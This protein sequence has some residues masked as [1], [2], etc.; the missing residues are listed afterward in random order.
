MK[1]LSEIEVAKERNAVNSSRL[2]S[3]TGQAVFMSWEISLDVHG[4][5]NQFTTLQIEHGKKPWLSFDFQCK[6]RSFMGHLQFW[7]LLL[8][9][10]SRESFQGDVCRSLGPTKVAEKGTFT[11]SSQ[12]TTYVTWTKKNPFIFTGKVWAVHKWK[13]SR[14]ALG[15][16]SKFRLKAKKGHFL[17]SYKGWSSKG[18]DKDITKLRIPQGGKAKSLALKFPWNETGG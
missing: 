5:L 6:A 12:Q 8:C 2:G 7:P 1:K 18:T 15:K 16:T 14:K 13:H 3:V 11:H 17:C 9:L 4:V 10:C